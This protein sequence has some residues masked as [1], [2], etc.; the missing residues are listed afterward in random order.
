MH[1]PN[2]LDSLMGI[3]SARAGTAKNQ[4]RANLPEVGEKFRSALEQAQPKVAAPKPVRAPAETT[5]KKAPEPVGAEKPIARPHHKNERADTPLREEPTSA[6][7]T[8]EERVETRP[9]AKHAKEEAGGA[10]PSYDR[11][12][13]DETARTDTA[14]PPGTDASQNTLPEAGSMVIVMEGDV[15]KW[16]AVDSNGEPST[17]EIVEQ[18][19]AL[20]LTQPPLD[21]AIVEPGKVGSLV[22]GSSLEGLDVKNLVITPASLMNQTTAPAVEVDLAMDHSS[23]PEATTMHGAYSTGQG[24]TRLAGNGTLLGQVSADQAPDFSVT[25]N[26]PGAQGD[27]SAAVATD[28]AAEFDLTL[29]ENPDFALL[30]GKAITGKLADSAMAPEKTTLVID[31]PKGSTPTSVVESPLRAGE[32]PS[33][34]ARSFTVQTGVPVPV[35]QPQWSQAVGEKVLWLAA[36]NVSAAEIRLDPP[37]LGPMQVKVSVNQDQ[38]SVTFTS[39]HPVVRDA[40]DQQLH[41]LREMFSEQGLNLVNVDVSDQPAYRQQEDNEAQNGKS[42]SELDDED[43]VPVATT[44]ISSLRLV[45]HY[46]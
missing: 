9:V 16:L 27:E 45:D 3:P 17:D 33:P 46:A 24:V 20:E 32:S 41:R 30:N 7:E 21:E 1:N 29:E 4:P 23:D 22:T 6:R 42:S 35:G 18:P 25:L 15:G 39:P 44:P 43:V 36:Q 2:L 10:E 40:L 31:T 19:L 5:V 34:A 8:G 11:V 28:T 13:G 12:A 38:A 14:L 37:D 26:V